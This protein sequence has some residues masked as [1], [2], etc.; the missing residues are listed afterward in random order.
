MERRSRRKNKIKIDD[1][2]LPESQRKTKRK[3]NDD[4]FPQAREREVS[5]PR[6]VFVCVQ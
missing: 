2:Y 4:V 6:R 3:K 1:K 5:N